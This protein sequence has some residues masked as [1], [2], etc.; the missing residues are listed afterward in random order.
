M[1]SWFLGFALLAL[2]CAGCELAENYTDPEGPRYAGE[3]S[4]QAQEALSRLPDVKLVTFNIKFGEQSELA[5]Q[6]LANSPELSGADIILL[7]EMDAEGTDFI[8]Q[9]LKQNYVYYPGSVQHGRDF[10]N[11]VLSRW[12]ILD[13]EKI[14]LPYKNPTDGRQRIA[15]RATLQTPLG[16]ISAYSI[17]N[18]TPWLGPRA[19]LEQAQSVLDDARQAELYTVIGGD[20]NSGDPGSLDATVELFEEAGF[21]WASRGAEDPLGTLDH[22]FV[23]DFVPLASGSVQSQASDH[24]PRWVTAELVQQ[25]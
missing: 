8:A 10:G 14:I 17:H 18:E 20:F 15:V 9:A 16:D 23:R 24:W 1:L 7:Q 25:P 13:D 6:D 4:E 12:P 3:Y 21:L 22:T 2:S 19:R 5:A 11:A